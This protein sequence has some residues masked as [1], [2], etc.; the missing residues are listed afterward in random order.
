MGIF[1]WMFG[2][3]GPKPGEPLS[4]PQLV[5]LIVQ[6]KVQ[7]G[8]MFTAYDITREAQRRGSRCA[9]VPSRIWSTNVLKPVQWARVIRV[10]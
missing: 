2:Q 4:T 5:K 8:A 3:G 10:P 9:M 6:E 1:D 7:A